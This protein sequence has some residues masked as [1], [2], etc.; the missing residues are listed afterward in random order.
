MTL[1]FIYVL[2]AICIASAA[3]FLCFWLTWRRVHA[4]RA[5]ILTLAGAI[6]LAILSEA[7]GA[8]PWIALGMSCVAAFVAF[9]DATHP[10]QTKQS[11]Q[12][13]ARRNV[14]NGHPRPL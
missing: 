9:A 6:V 2:D 14:Q 10:R 3:A 13:R 7:T 4:R 1:A 12:R 8:W 11:L 5:L